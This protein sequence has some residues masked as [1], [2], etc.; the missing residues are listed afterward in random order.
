MIKVSF[1]C[2][3]ESQA[4]RLTKRMKEFFELEEMVV[5]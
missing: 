5:D 4:D 2:D 3:D 1:I